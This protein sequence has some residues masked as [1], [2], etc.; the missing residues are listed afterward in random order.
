MA[1]GEKG[2]YLTRDLSLAGSYLILMPKN[3]HIGVS[4][5]VKDP[6]LRERMTRTGQA[7]AEG[8]FGLVMREAAAE[9]ETAVLRAELDS[10]LERWQ[11]ILEGRLA[12]V[13]AEE[14]I[15]LAAEYFSVP[16]WRSS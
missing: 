8:R 15:R 16:A 3:R 2:A 4:A 9:A 10:L 1:S 14:E 5:R 11:A 7:L 6:A 13:S 12:A